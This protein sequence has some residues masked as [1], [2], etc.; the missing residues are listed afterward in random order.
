[1]S[2][3][4]IVRLSTGEE[5]LCKVSVEG[6]LYTLEDLAL[7]VPTQQN[8]I[9]LAPYLPYAKTDKLSVDAKFVMYVIEPHEDLREQWQKVFGKI[10]TRDSSIII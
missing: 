4:K 3:P 7:I 9:G 2:D 1:M 5:L 6:D 8:S 10:I